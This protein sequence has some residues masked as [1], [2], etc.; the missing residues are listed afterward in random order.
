LQIDQLMSKKD[1]LDYTDEKSKPL[2]SLCKR[3]EFP[4]FHDMVACLIEVDS[5]VEVIHNGIV[6]CLESYRESTNDYAIYP[7]SRGEKTLI[8]LRILIEANLNVIQYG[9]T[10]E[11][12]W[13]FHKTC[14]C[15]RGE[16]GVAVL[17][18][19]LLIDSTK[20]KLVDEYGYLPIHQAVTWS[21]LDVVKLLL[22]AY[23]E[24][25]FILTNDDSDLLHLAFDSRFNFAADMRDKVEYI[26]DQC[27]SFIHQKNDDGSTPLH[28]NL[29]WEGNSFDLK[30]V[31][32]LCN[33]DETVVMDQCTHSD[34]SSLLSGWLPLH[35]L[36]EKQTPLSEISDAADCFRLFLRIYPASAGVMSDSVLSPYGLAVLHELN[37]YFIRLL[38][39]ADPTID[40]VRR[41]NLNF[42][43][44]REAMFLAFRALTSNVD[45]TIWAKL[46]YEHKDLLVHVISYL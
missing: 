1:I 24:S 33:V 22:K 31:I 45:A 18:L 29:E 19:L 17:S 15:L 35:I 8:L 28:C 44:R 46:R 30:S 6:Q 4:T 43:A 21:C 34:T 13:I 10:R 36:I 3:L 11:E 12:W 42:A 37:V 41:H 9:G 2:G 26:C 39:N 16:L 27:P 7:G 40:P 14:V 20:V 5:S 25:L 38:L 32:Y 23:P